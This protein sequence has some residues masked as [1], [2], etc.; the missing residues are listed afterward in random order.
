MWNRPEPGVLD[1]STTA[2]IVFDMLE[3]YRPAIERSGVLPT[4]VDLVD[5]CRA[6]GVLVCFARADHRP[7]GADFTRV[8]ADT[9]RDFMR[10]DQQGSQPTRPGH[11]AAD[12]YQALAEL[13]QGPADIDVPKHRWSAFH[14]TALDS[15]LR[16]QQI[17]TVMIVGGSTHVGVAS[18]AYAARD[19]D[20]QVIVVRDGCTGHEE[21]RTFFLDTVFPRM[22]QVKTAAEVTT[23]LSA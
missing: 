6:E 19:L 5:F 7:D 18:T 21:P 4:V 11:V 20:Y 12:G 17:E 23:L 14:G 8:I 16:V 2:L 13:R 1:R 3:I 9:D 15:T 10:W 22:V